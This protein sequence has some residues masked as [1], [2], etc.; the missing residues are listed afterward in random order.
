MQTKQSEQENLQNSTETNSKQSC[1]FD[2]IENTIFTIVNDPEKGYFLAIGA[3][4]IT[5][6]FKTSTKAIN[7]LNEDM[8]NIIMKM[9]IIVT[10]T[11]YKV[12]QDEKQ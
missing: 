1:N 8:W 2:Q 9:V 3:N 5:E 12:D 11:A 6:Y 7:Q 4:R 10:E